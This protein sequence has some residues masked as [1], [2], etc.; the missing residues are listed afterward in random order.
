MASWFKGAPAQL[1]SATENEV[2]EDF[3]TK[4]PYGLEVC[5]DGGHQAIAESVISGSIRYG[6]LRS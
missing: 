6:T 3:A 1:P 2:Q 5:H 4:G